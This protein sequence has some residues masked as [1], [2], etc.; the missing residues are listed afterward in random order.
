MIA[1]RFAIVAV[2][3]RFP[4]SANTPEQFWKLLSDG[5]DAITEIPPA[6]FDLEEV[7]D[8]DPSQPGKLYSR[9]GG[10]ADD[11]DSFDAEFF[12]I[13][14]REAVRIDPQQRLLL[15]VVWETIEDGGLRADRLAGSKTGVYIGISTHDYSDLQAN[16]ANWHR[17]DTYSSTGTASS[18]AANRISYA[19]DLRG[20]SFVVDTACSSSLTA[21]HLACRSLRNRECDLAIVGGVNAILTP[22]TAIGFCRASMLSPD[23]RC[24]AF[25]ASANGFVRGEGAGVVILKPLAAAMADNDRIYAVVR[26]TAIN[27][28][29]RTVGLMVPSASAQE[30]LIRE[31]FRDADVAPREVQYVEAHGTGT[32]VG[33]PIE[34]AAIGRVL[35]SGRG[36]ANPCLIGSVKTN[37][38]HLEAA[39]GIA[40]LIKTSL[41]LHHRMIPPS[42]HFNTANPDIPL[43]DLGL[44]VVT[45]LE[46]WPGNGVRALAGVNSFGFGGANAHAVLEEAPPQGAVE[47]AEDDES[48]YI[49]PVS[50]RCP[51]ALR[52]LVAR[53][54]N[55]FAGADAPSLRD[56]CYSAAIRRTHHLHRVAFIGASHAEMVEQIGT[57]LPRDN[58][59]PPTDGGSLRGEGS[60]LAFLFTGMGPQWWGMG[61]QLFDSEPRFREAIEECDRVFRDIGSWSLL[62]ALR[63]EESHSRVHEADFAPAANLA[64]QVGLTELWRSWGIVPEAIVGHS[65]GEIGAAWAAGALSL[66]DAFKVAFHRGQLQ[67]RLA[68]SGTMLAAG[69]PENEA[70]QLIQGL[71]DRVSIAAVNSPTS[72]TLSGERRVLEEIAAELDRRQRFHRFLPVEVPYHAPSFEALRDEFIGL[73]ASVAPLPAAVP[74]VSTVSGKW[75][76]EVLLDAH[77]WYA[78]LR[79]PVRFADAIDRL[80]QEEYDLFIEIGP[81]PV[82]AASVSECLTARSKSVVI[83]PS[84]R[85]KED[86]RRVLLRSLAAIYG[87]GRRVD[88]S[89]VCK[90]GRFISLPQYPW[91]RERH[92]FEGEQSANHA[93]SGSDSGHPLLGYRLRSVRPCWEIDLGQP[94]LEY[95]DDHI[96]QGSPVF[97]G[98]AYAEMA[99]EG[100]RAVAPDGI[101]VVEE[102]MFRKVLFLS[103][104][105]ETLLQFLHDPQSSSFEI[106]SGTKDNG[107]GWTLHASGKLRARPAEPATRVLD[108][109]AIRER[110]ASET[111]IEEA[112]QALQARG[113]WHQ[114]MFRGMEALWRGSGEALARIELVS[115]D[116]VDTKPYEVHPALLDSAFQAMLTA[117]ESVD[118]DKPKARGSFLPVSIKRLTLWHDPGTKFWSHSTIT[119]FESD[120]VE[121]DIT[122]VDDKGEVAVAI[123]GLRCKALEAKARATGAVLDEL[124]YQLNWE[125]KPLEKQSVR[126][127]LPIRGAAELGALMQPV[128]D[129]LVIERNWD[130]QLR[131]SEPLASGIAAH[132]A[133]ASLIRLGWEPHE[134]VPSDLQTLADRLGIATRH[135]RFLGR[136]LEI[137]RGA[138]DSEETEG[139]S[140]TE[141]L[142]AENL[143]ARLLEEF[144]ECSPVVD[145]LRR[146]GERLDAILM[147]AVDAR[148]VLFAPEAMASW[149]RF[150]VDIPWFDFYNLLVADSIAA[151]VEEAPH[152]T[153]LRV[154]EIGAGTGGTTLP[155]L[156]RL[157]DRKLEYH[158][159]DISTFFLARARDRFKDRPDVHVSVLDIEVDPIGQLGPK[160]FDVVLAANVLHATAD[161]KATLKHIRQLLAPGGL[162]VLLELASKRPWVDLI[163]GITEGWWRFTDFD[164]RP[165]YVLLGPQQWKGV[166]TESGFEGAVAVSEA[167]GERGP[168]HTMLLATLP[169]T[170]ERSVEV[171]APKDWIVFHDSTGVGERVT[172]SLRKR[173]DRCISVIRGGGYAR[174]DLETVEIAPDR[175][176]HVTRLVEELKT[177]GFGFHGLV[178]AMSLDA[179]CPKGLTASEVVTV[180]QALCGSVIALVQGFE[181]AGFPLPP[182]L[183]LTSDTQTIGTGQAG[184]NLTQAP[185]WGL[186]RVMSSELPGVRCRLVDLG[187][188]IEESE[189]QAL[190]DELE[191]DEFEEEVALRGS[192]RYV[193]R[194]RR[195]QLSDLRRTDLVRPLSPDLHQFRLEIDTPG[196]LESLTLREIVG[197][198]P[199]PGEVLIRVYAAGLNFRDVMLSLGM[200]PP[201]PIPGAGGK[202]ILGFECAGIVIECG[203]G[204]EDFHPGDEVVAVAIGA[205]ASQVVTRAEMV[206]RKPAHLTFEQAATIPQVFITAH[207]G[208]TH[209]ARLSAGERVLIHAATGGVGLAAI[210]LARRVGAEIFATAG[211]PEKRAYLKAMGIKQVMDSRSLAF[212]DEVLAATQGEGVDVVLNSLAGEAIPKGLSILRPYGRF[213]ELGKRDIYADASIGLLPFDRNLSFSSIAADRMLLDRPALV[214]SL[215]REIAALVEERA[216]EPIPHTA[217]DLSQAEEALRFLAQAKHIGKLVL[218]VREPAYLVA[219]CTDRPIC[220]PEATY[221]I[222]GGLG[223]FGL[224]IARW[225]VEKGAGHIVLM[226]RRGTPTVENQ[227]EFDALRESGADIVVFKGD[228]SIEEDVR[229]MLGEIREKL[230]P[231]RGVVHA[232]MVLDDSPVATMSTEQFRTAVSPK[233]AG[234]WNLHQLTIEDKLDF[235]VMLASA[236]S[237]LGAKGQGSYAAANHFLDALAPYR[238]SLGLPALTIDWG[239]IGEVGYLSRH[240]VVMQ[241][242]NSHGIEDV[243]PAEATE[244]LEHALRLGV[245]QMAAMRVDW[246]RYASIDEASVVVRKSK[247]L[248]DFLSAE[249]TGTHNTPVNRGSLMSLLSSAEPAQRQALVE[250][251]VVEQVARVL[252]T[253]VQKVDPSLRLTEMGVDSLMAVE[254]Q[255][256]VKRDFGVPLPLAVL[257]EGGSAAQLTARVLEQLALDATPTPGKTPDEAAPSVLPGRIESPSVVQVVAV[258]SNAEEQG[259][260]SE[261][262]MLEPPV[263]P[264][265]IS[266][267]APAV[268]HPATSLSLTYPAAHSP[269]EAQDLMSAPCRTAIDGGSVDNR[270]TPLQKFL[271]RGLSA[272]FSLVA[273]V[274][275]TGL[276]N[277]PRSGPVLLVCNHLSMIDL[278]LLVTIVPRRGTVMAADRLRA[279][280]W[281]RWFLDLGD[282]IYV[283]RGEAD[284]EALNRGL[285]VLRAGGML[286]VA[287]EGTRSRTGGLSRGRSGIAYLAATAPAPILPVALYGHEQ[288]LLNVRRLRRTPVQVRLG[289][290]IHIKPGEKSA[291]QLRRDTDQVMKA[292]AAMLPPAYR[293]V[294]A[295]AVERADSSL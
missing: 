156:Q 50:A 106:Y 100:A 14:P 115:G 45:K 268:A 198:R 99:L 290:F 202:T 231:L 1:D 96:V 90:T 234:A 276:D 84:L 29:G 206:A 107:A 179:S 47:A 288:I 66:K 118:V 160:P 241:H 72:V 130:E 275:V 226:S 254:L 61:R 137:A 218:T 220:L 134:P 157:A 274:E 126:E 111:P 94:S 138:V 232:A 237:L 49:L 52:E 139:S 191:A 190:L 93:P 132:F 87:R 26:G 162:L 200:L 208:L 210:Q 105:R 271:K 51:D 277:I 161:L 152:D 176:E 201:M 177:E 243:S 65:A 187:P 119:R 148:Q 217:Y 149:V 83:L 127:V 257:L 48:V 199:G 56:L 116:Q 122:L 248:A 123:E 174:R 103:H 224:A 223:G 16:P 219:P 32:R 89:G 21:F 158:F 145:L 55:M 79:H 252:G 212:A 19:Y 245:T 256:I 80:M 98:A 91:Q 166:L 246:A 249:Q 35:S 228:V 159:T 44:R 112:Y 150:F 7:F 74:L 181:K 95:L 141:Q 77:Y 143:C 221:V 54:R 284:Q 203:K 185:L 229:R 169:R 186:G 10:F 24:K 86:E 124:L 30:V 113:L 267:P 180:S 53:Y 265:G 260:H 227:P 209:L 121:S 68:R 5:T 164:L 240:P 60:K 247:R 133:R 173:G 28:D 175:P 2:G 41:A 8:A 110:C 235:F 6:R 205:L 279:L 13:S 250:R 125:A 168:F 85:R 286:G 40:G 171:R 211:N 15:E 213:L 70:L 34:A 144:P 264:G 104:R 142:A 97:P 136:L 238:R 239:A 23:G 184:R 38:G 69:V 17:V 285:A 147:G 214:G 272:F 259:A 293:G 81:H 25:D 262:S 67:Y 189:I 92:W 225:L 43:E 78:N 39:A 140:A 88:W 269:T 242:L 261:M 188:W 282:S 31:A 64:I 71:T 146:C 193:A 230:P 192:Q 172:G 120:A 270:W 163:F 63:A 292:I 129:R 73:L 178:H 155:V 207:Y 154:L 170:A 295:D 46:P 281:V 215:A 253:S 37:I 216:I 151:A 11:M 233:I 109:F 128:A 62:E 108:L 58:P 135:R 76:A 263:T 27:Q 101:A 18:I 197:T 22:A 167:Y 131:R 204:V 182:V 75:A 291:A 183:L 117:A 222:S 251:H 59:G 36:P 266:E 287:P 196:T 4:G 294:Y 289:S 82:L 194:L 165:D 244:A 42:L 12:G 195:R 278:P 280:P 57:F 258:A 236:T 153:R 273:R 114:G 3:C 20:P 283:R 9:W 33:D 255:T 102:V